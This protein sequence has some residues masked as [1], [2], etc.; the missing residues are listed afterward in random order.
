MRRW[1][2]T[3]PVY[4][5]PQTFRSSR[6]PRGTSWVARCHAAI[7]RRRSWAQPASG[8]TP[9]AATFERCPED[10]A[11]WGRALAEHALGH[12]DASRAALQALTAGYAHTRPF[13]IA[14]AHAWRG[15]K[16]AAFEW[17][18]RAYAQHQGGLAA[19][20]KT[21]PFLKSLRGDPRYAALLRR[22]KLPVD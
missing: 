22:M 13:D 20:V 11:Q 2:R 1:P 9:R 12:V 21:D 4:Q 14:E 19:I 6:A 18:E 10:Y 8:S 7:F 16:D 15:E 3:P 5:S 17:L